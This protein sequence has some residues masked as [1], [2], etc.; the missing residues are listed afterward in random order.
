MRSSVWLYLATTLM[1]MACAASPSSG[2]AAAAGGFDAGGLTADTA[3]NAGDGAGVGDA[4]V[5]QAKA[6]Q[7][8]TCAGGFAGTQ[9]C[10]DDQTGWNPCSCMV[11]SDVSGGG[12]STS[13]SGTSGGGGKDGG[14]GGGGKKDAGSAAD[15]AVDA[16]GAVDATTGGGG[17]GADKE[18][19]LQAN[20]QKQLDACMAVTSCA[21]LVACRKACKGDKTCADACAA[22]ATADA[23][24]LD[25]ALN[26]C[27]K[28]FG[29]GKAASDVDAGPSADVDAG[30]AAD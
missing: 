23:L 6:S 20:C 10:R 3:A 26:D 17:G 21:E 4:I 25:K 22:K 19:C 13:D 1:T 12:G 27:G 9:T 2:G 28:T 7:S 5:C 24:A 18:A 29:C 11:S 14:G 16:G 15:A 30:S 8:C